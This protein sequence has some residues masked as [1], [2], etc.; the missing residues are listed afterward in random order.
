MPAVEQLSVEA[1]SRNDFTGTRAGAVGSLPRARAAFRNFAAPVSPAESPIRLPVPDLAD[2]LIREI[3]QRILSSTSQATTS[4]FE[5]TCAVSH[6][7]CSQEWIKAPS[8]QS[9]WHME[10]E[11]RPGKR[12]PAIDDSLPIVKRIS[13][14]VRSVSFTMARKRLS[15]SGRCVPPGVNS[16]WNGAGISSRRITGKIV[17]S[18]SA[19]RSASDSNRTKLGQVRVHGDEREIDYRRG[20]AA[21]HNSRKLSSRER[22][23]AKEL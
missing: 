1:P 23:V 16:T 6:G 7:F 14:W 19:S 20:G 10:R 5:S 12:P 11:L 4:P 15:N 17:I 9:P 22:S 8:G 2:R 21:R 3:A 18:C 13:G